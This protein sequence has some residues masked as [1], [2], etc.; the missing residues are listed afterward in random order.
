MNKNYDFT[1]INNKYNSMKQFIFN[2]I[3]VIFLLF[4][5]SLFA[6]N[7]LTNGNF[8]SG[9]TGWNNLVG[10]GAAVY[11]LATGADVYEGTNSLKIDVTTAGTNA[12]DIQSLYGAWGAVSGTDYTI[13][14]W[15]K[16]AVAG[17]SFSIVQQV[18]STYLSKSFA[19][20]TTYTQYSWIFTAGAS[21]LEMKLQFPSIG[22]FYLDKFEIP[23]PSTGTTTSNNLVPNGNFEAD[24][25]NWQNLSTPAG[26]TFSIVTGTD[27]T[28]GTKAMKVDVALAGTNAYD[29]QSIHNGWSS[30][31]NTNYTLT[32]WGRASTNGLQ[33]KLV[34]QNS[35]YDEKT[36]TLT[37]TYTKYSWTFTAKEDGLKFRFN[38]PQAGTFYLDDVFIADP[39]GG[40]SDTT[41]SAVVSL[42]KKY[43]TMEGFG[44]ALTWYSDWI[45]YGTSQTQESFYKMAFDSLGIDILR[46]MNNYYPDNYLTNYPL[47]N[48]I[49]S[50][51]T[52]RKT[53]F[54]NSIEFAKRAKLY[55][56]NVDVLMCSWTPPADLK[57]NGNVYEGGLKKNNNVFMYSEYACYWQDVLTAYKT[58]GFTPD[59]VSIQNEPG[60][61]NAGWETCEFRPTETTDY[62]SYTTAFDSVYN[63]I[64]K[65]S[66]MPKLIGPE[67]ENIGTDADLSNANT[68]T[69]YTAPLK[70]KAGLYAYAYHL[71]NFSGSGEASIMSTATSTAL[72]VV[73]NGY[74]DKPNFMT[75]FG[76]LDWFNTALMI[77]QT[78]TKANASAYIHWE[79]AWD[80][81]S[82][83]AIALTSSGTYTL[84]PTYYVLKHFAKYVDKGYTRIDVANTNKQ[85]AISGYKNPNKNQITMVVINR[86]TNA[87]DFAVNI[88]KTIS[89]SKV[90][91]SVE[92]NY[93]QTVAG[94]DA[95][96]HLSLPA[97][98]ISTIVLDY[99]DN[100]PITQ[101]ISLEQGWNLIST[102]V[103]P[104][105]STIAT[106]FTG[107][108]VSEIKNMD[109]YW[110]KGQSTTL[111]SLKTITSGQG[112]FVK[113]NVAATLKVTG[114]PLSVT[115]NYPIS[116]FKTGWNLTGCPYQLATTFTSAL[117]T[118]ISMVTLLKNFNGFYFPSG[119][120]NSISSFEP[121]K[122]YFFK[123][124]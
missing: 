36:I 4:P 93:F 118:D 124:K 46:V 23:T 103:K 85:L 40:V 81:N 22:T 102:N 117:S 17:Q 122:G 30:V 31:L 88:G 82:S 58:A 90:F 69:S 29:I 15:A 5:C 95:K 20:T 33:V 73:K 84:K 25:T 9:V 59:Y 45:K 47:N 67:V 115:A 42:A 70:G 27:A 2:R 34:Q 41:D 63:R 80:D 68:Y 116:T 13:T 89:S 57:S 123:K 106:L 98:S 107:I 39:M 87:V 101:S 78:V 14:F 96:S 83:T 75:E 113:M 91:Q 105:D 71:Y 48:T 120:T 50:L 10:S 99:I 72:D 114:I 38:F 53:S 94:V 121:G 32:F 110:L 62:A 12:W 37:T 77:Q 51:P 66:N 97:R 35:T 28:E 119:T 7:M 76:S 6:Q 65:Q 26:N 112:Y 86:A 44:G 74:T 24:F 79:L 1:N 3:L 64:S 18:G 49:T 43:Q 61:Q 56:P 55:N 8:E 19:L 11:S 54:N 60:F 104:T 92:N 108:D 52:S 109:V 16:A 100:S 21:A 111:N